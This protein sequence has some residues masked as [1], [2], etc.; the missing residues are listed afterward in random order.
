[1]TEKTERYI[2][3]KWLRTYADVGIYRKTMKN[4]SLSN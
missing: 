4:P 3:T 1:M 2:R